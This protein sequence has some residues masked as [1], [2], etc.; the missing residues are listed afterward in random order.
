VQGNRIGTNAA[1]NA[2]LPNDGPGVRIQ[3]AVLTTVGGTG[4]SAAN[5]IAYNNGTGIEVR[6]E[7]DTPW[8]NSL[9]RNSIFAND[10]LGIDLLRF[11]DPGVT[12][13]DPG[14]VDNG[15]NRFQNYPVLSSVMTAGNRTAVIGSL[16]S[17]PGKSFR[18]EFF[19]NTA[20]DP[21]GFG[22]GQT[23]LGSGTV[24]TGAS[25]DANFSFIF[26]TAVPAG[27]VVTATATSP[28]GDTSEFS[29]V[30]TVV[31]VEGAVVSFTLVDAE[32]D[33]D[34]FTLNDGDVIDLEALRN[35]RVNI[36]ANTIGTVG[37]VRFGYDQNP[38]DFDASY[39]IEN[40]SPFALFGDDEDGDYYGRTPVLGLHTLSATP[41]SLDDAEGVL[42]VGRTIQFTVIDSDD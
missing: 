7:D 31:A 15:P 14:D 34:L 37:S 30:K 16:N 25:G 9:L 29:A 12:P 41:F 1:G 4:S 40:E 3:G 20:A 28:D 35:R 11:G 23:F 5:L 27:Q 38:G 22:E 26:N 36:R 2:A 39:R 19:S 6:E 13:N 33:R 24:K 21:S 18:V 8:G 42:G 17:T 10:G 32:R